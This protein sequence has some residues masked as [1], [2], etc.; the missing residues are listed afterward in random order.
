MRNRLG[1]RLPAVKEQRMQA[2]TDQSLHPLQAEVELTICV[3]KGEPTK[4]TFLV[5]L[6]TIQ[7][8]GY[9]IAVP[10]VPR[11]SAPCRYLSRVILSQAWRFRDA[12]PVIDWT[13]RWW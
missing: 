6:E 5:L 2:R 1:N 4:L 7:R 9:F 10:D 11:M 12:C 8:L 3:S 13:I